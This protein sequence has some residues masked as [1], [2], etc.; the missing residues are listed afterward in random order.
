SGSLKAIIFFEVDHCG[1]SETCSFDLR[2]TLQEN[3]QEIETRKLSRVVNDESGFDKDLVD[4][5][6]GV[7]PV[8]IIDIESDPFTALPELDSTG[9]C[10]NECENIWVVMENKNDQPAEIIVRMMVPDGL[11]L[12]VGTSVDSDLPESRALKQGVTERRLKMVLPPQSRRLVPLAAK[13]SDLLEDGDELG[14]TFEHCAQ[15][16]GSDTCFTQKDETESRQFIQLL[17]I[18]LIIV[19]RDMGDAP[20]NQNH[21]GA[22]MTI[23]TGAVAKFPV[24]RDPAV[25]NPAPNTIYGP[26]HRFSYWFHLGDRVSQETDVDRGIDQD[27]AYNIDPNADVADQDRYDDGIDINSVSFVDCQST[28]IPVEV[29]I[30]QAAVNYFT[31]TDADGL[32]FIN[33]WFDSD[34]DGQWG[35]A[36]GL[37]PNATEHILIDHPVDVAALGVGQH[38]INVTTGPVDLPGLIANEPRWMRVM[39]SDIESNKDLF[40]NI[41]DGRGEVVP[42]MGGE[43]EDYLWVPPTAPSSFAAADMEVSV[44]IRPVGDEVREVEDPTLRSTDAKAKADGKMEIIFRN[45]G[46]K[47]AEDVVLDIDLGSLTQILDLD[48]ACPPLCGEL[49]EIVDQSGP[50]SLLIEVADPMDPGEFGKVTLGWKGCLT[51]TTGD[52]VQSALIQVRA[53]E[54]LN[55]ENSIQTLKWPP[56]ERLSPRLTLG[57]HGCLTCVR[58]IDLSIKQVQS[59]DLPFEIANG[60]GLGFKVLK[61]GLAHSDATDICKIVNCDPPAFEIDDTLSA[62]SIVGVDEDGNETPPS[63]EIVLGCVNDIVQGAIVFRNVATGEL[64]RLPASSENNFNLGMPPTLTQIGVH[65]CGEDPQPTL[66]LKVGD[67]DVVLEADAVSPNFY[68][69]SFSL[70]QASTLR[71]DGPT[72]ISLEVESEGTLYETSIAVETPASGQ[73]IDAATGAALSGASITVLVEQET[74]FGDETATTLVQVNETALISNADGRYGLPVENGTYALII[75]L[76]GYQTYRTTEITV[77]DGELGVDVALVAAESAPTDVEITIDESGFAETVLTVEV[78]DV[79]SFV[80]VGLDSHGVSGDSWSSGLL[81]SGERFKRQFNELGIYPLRD[82]ANPNTT[83]TLVVQEASGPSQDSGEIYMPFIVSQ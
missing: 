64:R 63:N 3:G 48:V 31:N 51:C 14:I 68:V 9:V 11:K 35:Q 76:D 12:G 45:K 69:G 42:Y 24:S 78:G 44:R 80:N 59:V 71:Q 2:A 37:C 53:L 75:S 34:L 40:I 46:Y 47:T 62:Y 57:W 25:L 56:I 67:L 1:G 17:T 19:S 22:Q 27:I 72:T 41:G 50:G 49:G 55:L 10:L 58:S 13:I 81:S 20:T 5:A 73:I 79:V 8:N 21:F 70:E 61:D 38:T 36:T 74:T 66:K 30:S 6:V 26:A 77:E 52:G 16:V 29:N 43:T 39:L 54:D 18:Y 15:V 28:T 65:Y 33:M 60:S 23:P 83:A 82:P 4:V 32:A 7:P